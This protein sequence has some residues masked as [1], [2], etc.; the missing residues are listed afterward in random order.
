MEQSHEPRTSPINPVSSTTADSLADTLAAAL[1]SNYPQSEDSFDVS[2]SQTKSP[3]EF[4]HEF[5]PESKVKD[6]LKVP[7]SVS[8]SAALSSPEIVAEVF[9]SLLQ[10]V[11]ETSTQTLLDTAEAFTPRL[12]E[13]ELTNLTESIDSVDSSGLNDSTDLMN[14]TEPLMTIDSQTDVA[15]DQVDQSEP[16]DPV[17]LPANL[18]TESFSLYRGQTSDQESD[19][20]K[21]QELEKNLTRNLGETTIAA[22]TEVAIADFDRQPT[23]D[24]NKIETTP[25]LSMST[26]AVAPSASDSTTYS[27]NYSVTHSE[28]K[29]TTNFITKATA[30][31]TTLPKSVQLR[32]PEPRPSRIRLSPLTLRQRQFEVGQFTPMRTEQIIPLPPLEMVQPRSFSQ[33][34]TASP[35]LVQQLIEE[36]LSK[37]IEQQLENHIHHKFSQQLS[38][39]LSQDLESQ[40]V[41]Q[42]GQQLGTQIQQQVSQ[43]VSQ[44]TLQQE[45]N[46]QQLQQDLK[47]YLQTYLQTQLQQ[48]LTQIQQEIQQQILQVQQAQQ[49]F[50]Q[51]LSAQSQAQIHGQTQAQEQA[52][53]QVQTQLSQLTVPQ[54]QKLET[55]LAALEKQFSSVTDESGP[56]M[57]VINEILRSLTPTSLRQEVIRSLVPVIDRVIRDR[58]RQNRTAM[59]EAIAEVLPLA[60]SRHIQ[61]QPCEIAAAIAPEM[62]EA[63]RRQIAL[64]EGELADAI[65]SEMGAAI[66]KQVALERESMVDALYPVIGNTIS[67]YLTEEIRTINAKVEQ[68]FS[69]EGISRKIRSRIHGVSEAELILQESRSFNVKAAF[70]IHKESG[71]II[72]EAQQVSEHQ[73]EAD[74]IGGMLTA[75][76]SFANDC[77][78]Q[79][80]SGHVSELNEI[81]YDNFKLILEVAGYCYIALVIKGSITKP[82][83]NHLRIALSKIVQ[84]YGTEIKNFDGDPSSINEEVFTL[85]QDLVPTA[86]NTEKSDK[87]RNSNNPPALLLIAIAGMTVLSIFG[88]RQ[89]W[90]RRVETQVLRVIDT[91]P[92][93]T[94]YQLHVRARGNYLELTGDLPYRSLQQK[95]VE[96]VTPLVPDRQVIDHTQLASFEPD[97]STILAAVDRLTGLLNKTLPATVIAHYADGRVTLQGWAEDEQVLQTIGTAFSDL[98]GV[99][100]VSSTLMLD[101]PPSELRF[102]FDQGQTAPIPQLNERKLAS[103]ARFLANFPDIKLKV[104]GHAD[105]TGTPEQNK[106]LSQARAQAI[107]QDLLQL[108]V[109]PSRLI[110]EAS[111]ELPPGITPEQPDSLSRCVRFEVVPTAKSSS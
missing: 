4:Q 51:Q 22:V 59:S 12:P 102:F 62:A 100:T 89:A 53:A 26:D 30:E 19:Q 5:Q 87:N 49:Q 90:L 46:T 71:L 37:E 108:G 27:A 98:P 14:L 80:D 17:H 69:L 66:K 82:Y 11:A 6:A 1:S 18:D 25:L 84:N 45:Q 55:R 106:L 40:L 110:L 76:R 9:D 99:R 36:S 23:Q 10:V 15:I 52:Q 43:Q 95:L 44:K 56:I 104:I 111:L 20:E 57:P 47:N 24:L 28:K 54:L 88:A 31:A 42:L 74:M 63:L 33:R 16:I 39:Q 105:R 7:N 73:L 34:P 83:L 72:A 101:A 97:D 68:S 107:R 32:S 65:S 3:A 8:H 109:D 91:T 67:K 94:I 92:E 41:Q 21:D 86:I 96:V 78:A 2:E 103:V 75:I 70:L 93:L 58:T 85:I 35:E 13:T 79:A 61:S 50:K 29:S 60:I 48:E 64:A 38:Q 81:E 77:I